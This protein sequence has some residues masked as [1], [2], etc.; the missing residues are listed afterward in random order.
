MPTPAEETFFRTFT[1]Y[2]D[3]RLSKGV[4]EPAG[5][6]GDQLVYAFTEFLKSRGAQTGERFDWLIEKMAKMKESR[7]TGQPPPGAGNR[8]TGN[9]PA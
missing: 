3:F 4:T 8:G 5:A 9:T 6:L 7:G 2:V 1:Q